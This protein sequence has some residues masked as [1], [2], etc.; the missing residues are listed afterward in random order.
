MG[1]KGGGRNVHGTRVLAQR[2][3]EVVHL[4]QDTHH[5][6][7]EKDISAGVDKLV[8]ARKC[9]FQ[10]YAECFTAEHRQRSNRAANRNIDERVLFAV[11]RRNLVDH[12]E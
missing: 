4:R 1:R 10:C 8:H 6:D 12:D 5:H 11:Y 3:V 2:F 7:N 9:Q